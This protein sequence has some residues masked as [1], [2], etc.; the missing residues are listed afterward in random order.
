M[1]WDHSGYRCG[2]ILKDYR[3][4]ED[5]DSVVVVDSFDIAVRM[6]LVGVGQVKTCMVALQYL[7]LVFGKVDTVMVVANTSL[8]ALSVGS[9]RNARSDRV[10]ACS[11]T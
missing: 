6:D 11:Y 1:N 2:C 4:T 9:V 5:T 8:S 10:G 7:G 3:N